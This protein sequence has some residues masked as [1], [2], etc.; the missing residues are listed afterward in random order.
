MLQGSHD[1]ATKNCLK[2][3]SLS[4]V[5]V[6]FREPCQ[7]LVVRSQSIVQNNVDDCISPFFQT[8]SLG[9]R[10]YDSKGPSLLLEKSPGLVQ[11]HVSVANPLLGCCLY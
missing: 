6:W 4:G 1:N 9:R 3:N 7:S 2:K 11:C 8:L 10:D 5:W